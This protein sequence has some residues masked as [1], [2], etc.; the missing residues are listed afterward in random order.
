MDI[1]LVEALAET[2]VILT[3]LRRREEAQLHKKRTLLGKFARADE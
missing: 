2:I 1:A 3:L